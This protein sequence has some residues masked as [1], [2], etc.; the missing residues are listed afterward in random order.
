MNDQLP[1][2][3]KHV[4]TPQKSLLRKSRLSVV[5]PNTLTSPEA[6]QVSTLQVNLR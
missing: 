6:Q 5:D 3:N 2:V 4:V 1:P